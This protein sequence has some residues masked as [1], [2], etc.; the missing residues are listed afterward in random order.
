MRQASS[1][2]VPSLQNESNALAPQNGAANSVDAEAIWQAAR[3]QLAMQM[4]AATYD[5]W[6]RDTKVVAYEDG[7][8]IIGI[9]NAYVRDWLENRLRNKI[10]KTL[11]ALLGRSVQIN[12]RVVPPMTDIEPERAFAPLYE[13]PSENGSALAR[14]RG[15]LRARSGDGQ[16]SPGAV[17][18][19]GAV[20]N[21][22]KTVREDKSLDDD[23]LYEQ[24]SS[25]SGL[26]NVDDH[27][28]S[29][30]ANGHVGDGGQGASDWR[31]TMHSPGML[32]PAHTFNNFV[33]GNHNRLAHAA[34]QAI[35]ESPGQS[36]N[37]LFVY[38]GVGLGKTH[39]LHAVGNQAR[40]QGF[41]L[42]Y[43]SSEQFTHEL[44]MAIRSQSTEDFRNKYRQVDMLLIDDIQFIGGKEST[45]E[46]FFHTF[47]YLHAAGRQVVLSS[48]RP[49]K[50][51]AT[52]D[53]RL[54][55][56]F[57]GGLQTDIS[58]PDFETRVAILQSKALKTDLRIHRDVLMLIAERVESN[59]RE[60]EGVLNRMVLQARLFST[61]L[62]LALAEN[63]LRNLAPQRTP[64]SP[65]IVIRVVAEY[66]HLQPDDL[67]GRTRT[68]DIAHARQVAMYLLREENALSLPAIGDH[69]GGRDHST[70]RYGVDK[71]TGDL[72]DDE[73][74][75]R[76]IT[77][78]RE[79]I[80]MEPGF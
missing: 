24:E 41:R 31:G 77:T 62:D 35:A 27:F 17:D 40:K 46:E 55:S 5:T 3:S 52:L 44:I 45:Q 63:I 78:L 54:R 56:R 48:D 71:I 57:E 2:T 9:P 4:P 23:Y 11:S 13:Q 66:Y 16:A 29:Y 38:G 39:L 6:M 80:Y 73:T 37:P 61:S 51:L 28:G 15:Q 22:P 33:V 76:E 7:E 67:T 70:V 36:F 34:A 10:K 32:N 26:P 75:R 72:D 43:C 47:N 18:Q 49:P 68:K 21:L 74:L 64:R 69:L 30:P 58:Q 1:N 25:A 12:F 53:D 8:F 20:P 59:V 60:L 14:D 42:L 50:A 65:S 19:N 79:K